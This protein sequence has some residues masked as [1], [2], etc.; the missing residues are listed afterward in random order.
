M[1]FFG[2]PLWAILLLCLSVLIYVMYNEIDT[3]EKIG[4]L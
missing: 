4:I 3:V 1:D 2:F